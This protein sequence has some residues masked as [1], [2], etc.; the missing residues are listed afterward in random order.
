MH[1]RIKV[2]AIGAVLLAIS[3]AVYIVLPSNAIYLNAVIINFMLGLFFIYA[4]RSQ[5]FAVIDDAGIPVNLTGRVSGIVSCLG[6]TPDLFMY[7]LVGSWMDNYGRAGFDMTW[8]YA[9]VCAILCVFFSFILSR[10]I[11]KPLKASL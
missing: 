3:F 4:V 1:S 10:L 11:K 2:I 5:Y 9:V 8:A 6:Y 7:T